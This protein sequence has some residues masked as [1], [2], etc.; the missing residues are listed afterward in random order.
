MWTFQQDQYVVRKM[1]TVEYICIQNAI[2]A[3][4]MP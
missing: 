3:S 2:K 4:L 1:L